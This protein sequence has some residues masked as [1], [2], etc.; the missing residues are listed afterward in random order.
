L[1][2]AIN[3]GANDAFILNQM[4]R[5]LDTQQLFDRLK[6]SY[7]DF[8]KTVNLPKNTSPEEILGKVSKHYDEAIM[9]AFTLFALIKDLET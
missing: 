3:E 8:L 5:S 2:A 1:L 6:D 7:F 4:A 9:G